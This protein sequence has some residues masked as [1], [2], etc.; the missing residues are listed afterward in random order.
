[1][2]PPKP[3]KAGSLA[4][5]LE[6]RLTAVNTLAYRLSG[7]RF[8]A[9]LKGAPI[10]LLHHVGRKSGEARVSPLLYLADGDDYV[11]VA[12]HG[13]ADTSPAWYY[14][15]KANP[16]TLIVIGKREVQVVAREADDAERD[17]LWPLAAGMYSDYDVYA[18]RTTRKIPVVI[19]SPIA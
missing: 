11:L 14:N 6:I 13:G 1:V 19:L 5:K 8:G 4:S 7:G 2:A 3:P 16:E 9:T 18:T 10:L 17:R 15:L 12:S